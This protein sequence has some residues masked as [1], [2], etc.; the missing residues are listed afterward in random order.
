MMHPGIHLSTGPSC[1]QRAANPNPKTP[2]ANPAW[3]GQERQ[4][5]KGF[6]DGTPQ[7]FENPAK[8]VLDFFDRRVETLHLWRPW[9]RGGSKF[10]SIK[11]CNKAC[12]FP[13]TPRSKEQMLRPFGETLATAWKVCSLNHG[14]PERRIE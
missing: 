10:S 13:L 12:N 2:T 7:A 11:A 6:L 14:I 8:R 4:R 9:R 5:W 1:P 3:A